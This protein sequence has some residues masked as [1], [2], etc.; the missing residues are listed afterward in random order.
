MADTDPLHGVRLRYERA[1]E[2]L[3][4]IRREIEP[5]YDNFTQVRVGEYPETGGGY[6]VVFPQV[7]EPPPGLS[8]RVGEMIYNLRAALDYVVFELARHDSGEAQEGTQFPI[9]DREDVF[10]KTRR[11]TYLKGI[12]DEH[13]ALIEGYQPYKG[14]DWTVLLRQLS[15]PDKHRELHL[16]ISQLDDEIEVTHGHHFSADDLALIDTSNVD[17]ETGR[18]EVYIGRSRDV[19]VKLD[20]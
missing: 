1:G 3:A 12:S 13:L 6:A 20:L 10:R 19:H 11:T 18:P 7:Q 4:D 8:V 14:C 17:A 2:H 15:N 5:I 9:E 16:L